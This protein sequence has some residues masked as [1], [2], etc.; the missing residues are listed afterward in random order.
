M[1][2]ALACTSDADMRSK[3]VAKCYQTLTSTLMKE[4]VSILAVAGF[5]VPGAALKPRPP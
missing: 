3:H 1:V 5:L 4:N 2:K